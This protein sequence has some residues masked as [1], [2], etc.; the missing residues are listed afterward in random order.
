MVKSIKSCTK[1]YF[2]RN[3]CYPILCWRHGAMTLLIHLRLKLKFL[4]IGWQGMMCSFFFFFFPWQVISGLR[5]CAMI[6]I[7]LQ[8]SNISMVVFGIGARKKILR[9]WLSCI[10]LY[11]NFQRKW[12]GNLHNF[13]LFNHHVYRWVKEIQVTNKNIIW[14]LT[15]F[16]F[17]FSHIFS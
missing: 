16:L 11:E 17:F 7:V 3:W 15:L 8:I 2:Y 12:I 4:E 10:W 14:D 5:R 6:V 1:V 9:K 13:E